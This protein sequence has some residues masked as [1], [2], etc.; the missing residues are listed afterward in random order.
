MTIEWDNPE[1]MVLRDGSTY[2]ICGF[3]SYHRTDG[4]AIMHR[5]GDISWW[6]HD[7]AMSFNDWVIVSGCSPELEVMLKLQYG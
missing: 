6:W 7:R 1:A 2:Y 5:N 3:M 4:P